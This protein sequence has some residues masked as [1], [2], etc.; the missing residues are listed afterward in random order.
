M[1]HS[2]SLP[3]RKSELETGKHHISRSC[4]ASWPILRPNSNRIQQAWAV[5]IPL[6]HKWP[7]GGAV[8]PLSELLMGLVWDRIKGENLGLGPTLGGLSNE[9]EVCWSYLL[10]L[11]ALQMCWSEQETTSSALS[12][13]KASLGAYFWWRQWGSFFLWGILD[14]SSQV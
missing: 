14:N 4:A 13:G 12:G 3:P 9:S 2:F 11:T 1:H 10:T 7:R 6:L 8:Y 5:S